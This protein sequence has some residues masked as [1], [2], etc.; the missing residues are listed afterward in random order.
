MKIAN[1][2]AGQAIGSLEDIR[3]SQLNAISPE[4][5]NLVRKRIAEGEPSAPT[6][7]VAAFNSAM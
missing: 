6:L 5:V 2:R 3:R 7:D 1:T 4:R